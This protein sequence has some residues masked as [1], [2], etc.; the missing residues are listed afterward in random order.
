MVQILFFYAGHVSWRDMYTTTPS[1]VKGHSGSDWYRFNV[2]LYMEFC[3]QGQLVSVKLLGKSYTEFGE[4]Y[5][6]SRA[7][8]LTKEVTVH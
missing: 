4:R 8:V 6:V 1:C 3:L 5:G 7:V 2:W